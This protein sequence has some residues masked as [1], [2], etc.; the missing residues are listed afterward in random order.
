LYFNVQ[1][2]A[3]WIGKKTWDKP[4]LIGQLQMVLRNG[5]FSEFSQIKDCKT[6]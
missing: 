2:V 5:N 6:A 3:K 4:F 1:A